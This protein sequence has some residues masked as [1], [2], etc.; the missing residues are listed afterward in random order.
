M[1]IDQTRRLPADEIKADREALLALH[2]LRDYKPMNTTYG[3]EA[4]AALEAA[5]TQAQQEELRL[6]NAL[7]AARDATTA[8]A[9]A[10]H[11]GI[12]GAKAQV[13]AQYGPDSDAIHALGLKKK[14]ER[15]RPARRNG[16]TA[17]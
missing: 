7:A 3:A 15:R 5:L 11:T 14:S 13:I 10:L 16:A 17:R 12:Q 1:P 2:E 8:A 4:L 6:Q 9:W